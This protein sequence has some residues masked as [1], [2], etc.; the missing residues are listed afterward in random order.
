M[1]EG[2]EEGRAESLGDGELADGELDGPVVGSD[3]GLEEGPL[4]I[5]GLLEGDEEGCAE[6]LGG[7]D[8]ESE[9]PVDG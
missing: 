2:D 4:L 7:P 1:L 8:G 6:R 9:G 5:L 3:E